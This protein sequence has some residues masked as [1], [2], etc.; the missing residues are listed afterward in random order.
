MLLV[1]STLATAGIINFMLK[2]CDAWRV[3]CGQEISEMEGN[4]F[5]YVV[6]WKFW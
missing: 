1:A 4:F 3:F 2:K 5:E 6:M